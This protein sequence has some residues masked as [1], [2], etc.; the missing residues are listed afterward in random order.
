VVADIRALPWADASMD[1]VICA[2]NAVPHLLTDHDIA[3]AS[4]E[5]RRS[6]TFRLHS[7]EPVPNPRIDG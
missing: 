2:D 5:S 3:R 7:N 1:A 6:I 4:A